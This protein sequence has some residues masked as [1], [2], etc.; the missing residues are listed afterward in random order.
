MKF[1]SFGE[2][3]TVFKAYILSLMA[4]DPTGSTTLS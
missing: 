3:L 2:C 1:R 4:T